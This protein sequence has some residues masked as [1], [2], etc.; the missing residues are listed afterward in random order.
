MQPI[1]RVLRYVSRYPAL[2]IGTILLAILSTIMVFV[3]PSVTQHV[4]DDAI[5]G[6]RPDLIL[7]LSMIAVCSFLASNIANGIR[8]ILNNTFEQKVIFDIR[9]DLYDHIQKLPLRWFDHRSTGDIMTRVLEDVN[10]V[11]AILIDG[12]EQGT[13]AILQVVLVTVL[14]FTRQPR[15]AALTMLPL[16]FL[17]FGALVYTIT[18]RSRYRWRRQ[19]ASTMNSLLHDNLS[20]IRQIKAYALEQEEHRGFN[21]ASEQVKQAAL[22]VMRAWALYTPSM[23]FLTSCGLVIV[24]GF[25][26][27]AV[28]NGELEIGQLVAFLILVRFLYEP[29]GKLHSLNQMLQSARA[30]G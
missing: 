5:R 8:I 20:G 19:A 18:A 25:G 7:P 27:Q 1:L 16:P 17:V 29:I 15:L 23:E 3:F 21:G 6:H 13:V 28:L 11:E 10:A 12:I 4:I 9:S 2:A 14:L 22:V 26:G 30:A 24:T